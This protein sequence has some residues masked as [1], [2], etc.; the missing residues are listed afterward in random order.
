MD[1]LEAAE[2]GNEERVVELLLGAGK[3]APELLRQTDHAGRSALHVACIGGQLT[4]VQ[5]LLGRT[6]QVFFPGRSLEETEELVAACGPD[7]RVVMKRK[8][9]MH[10]P[11]AVLHL[12]AHVVVQPSDLAHGRIYEDDYGNAPIQCISCFGCGSEVKHIQD[13]LDIAKELLRSGCQTNTS[14]TSNNWTPLHWCAFNGNHEMTALLLHPQDYGGLEHQGAIPLVRSEG[15]Y[16]VDIAG[17]MGVKLADEMAELQ[18]KEEADDGDEFEADYRAWRLRLDHKRVVQ[19]FVDDFLTHAAESKKY[20]SLVT[21]RAAGTVKTGARHKSPSFTEDDVCRYG[22]HLLY[23]SSGLNLLP[24]V[25]AL[26]G[27]VFENR[28][29][30]SPLYP[31]LYEETKTQSAVHFASANGFADIVEALVLRTKA[32]YSSSQGLRKLVTTKS[33]IHP[34][35]SDA[36]PDPLHQDVQYRSLEGWLNYRNESPLFM[37]G[38]HNRVEVIQRFLEI[39]PPSHIQDEITM[40][41]IEGTTLREISNDAIRTALGLPSR[42]AFPLEYVLVFRRADAFFRKTLQDVLEEESSRAPSVLARSIGSRE[43]SCGFWSRHSSDRFDYMAV[44]ATDTVLAQKAE[45]LQLMVRKR[46]TRRMHVFNVKNRH[47]FEPFPSLIRQLVVLDLIRDNVNVK[48]HLAQGMIYDIFP[49]HN[50]TG[51][52]SIEAHWVLRPGNW[53]L[54][55]WT[56]LAHY[57]FE[58]PTLNYE[59]LWPLRFYFGDKHTLYIAWTQFSTAYMIA[60]ALPCLIVEILKSSGQNAA[61]PPLVLLMLVWITYLVEMWKRKRA[62]LICKWGMPQL[63]DGSDLINDEFHGDYVVDMSTNERDVRFPETLHV[64]RIYLGAPP[65]MIMVALAVLSFIG[66]KYIASHGNLKEYVS[67]VSAIK[68]VAILVLDFLYTKVAYALTYWENHRTVTEF[69]SMLA[70]KLFW[71]K[72]INAFMA[73]FWTAFVDC[74]IDQLRYDLIMILVFRQASSIGLAQLLPLL[75]VRYRWHKAGFQRT[76][77]FQVDLPTASPG[78]DVDDCDVPVGIQMQEMMEEPIHILTKQIDALI[79]FGYVAM[80]ATV[81]PGAPCFVA[82]TNTLEMHLDV[83]VSLEARRRPSFD[84]ETETPVFMNFVQ[85]MSFAAVTVNCGLLYLTTDIDTFLPWSFDDAGKLWVMLGIEH[86][87]L[88]IKASLVFG[89]DDVPSWVTAHDA[90]LDKKAS[91]P[92]EQPTA[93]ATPPSAQLQEG[94]EL[95]TVKPV[96]VAD[97]FLFQVEC[98]STMAMPPGADDN[99][100]AECHEPTAMSPPV[101]TSLKAQV[102]ALEE[103]LAAMTAARDE[104]IAK[105]H[106]VKAESME[107][108]CGFC[109]QQTPCQVKCIECNAVMCRD[110]D[111][112]Q[113]KALSSHIRVDVGREGHAVKERLDYVQRLLHERGPSIVDIHDLPTGHALHLDRLETTKQVSIDR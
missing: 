25:K 46:G 106:E 54:Q 34:I 89:I 37:A 31:V 60:I 26:L 92:P 88:S 16:P 107:N 29:V 27:L 103:A 41:T 19:A 105:L 6:C 66:T 21:A 84:G 90:R 81:F 91:S 14:K 44:G 70:I 24:Q 17:R 7:V 61:V 83:Q 40:Q 76:Q 69:E 43:H 67:L 65:L 39:L 86:I 75:R 47:E 36:H 20:A 98:L 95:P 55:P 22:Q 99:D 101:E 50:R 100:S 58:G 15:F 59:M 93:A 73:L 63:C 71:F 18:A 56:N 109:T 72:F 3:K 111:A 57:W 82:L 74:A 42:S 1:L 4:V 13:G 5:L 78:H 77:L 97:E 30:L 28:A 85:F 9:N 23:W 35:A 113:H 112:L 68:A 49:L 38:M 2:N 79:R 110:C 53:K 87:L 96:L 48:H 32:M 52:S 94:N 33:R 108:L 12:P 102:E 8:E 10:V 80:F 51:V 62:E 64:L 45:S 104:A 11:S